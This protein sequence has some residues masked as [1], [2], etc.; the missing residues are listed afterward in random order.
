MEFYDKY[1]TRLET[2]GND[3]ELL[4][5]LRQEVVR[6]LREYPPKQALTL[7]GQIVAAMQKAA[8]NQKPP[9]HQMV[10]AVNCVTDLMI[11]YLEK[12]GW[13]FRAYKTAEGRKFH[14]AS[15]VYSK[16]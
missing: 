8:K 14:R 6:S 16:V 2:E 4:D 10:D 9:E 5:E 3:P 13:R 7:A 11:E 15:P 12:V 1:I